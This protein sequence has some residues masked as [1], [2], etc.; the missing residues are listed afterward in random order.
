M[1]QRNFQSSQKQRGTTL[2]E[3][4][5][6]VAVTLALVTLA[7]GIYL[8]TH[9]SQNAR[10]RKLEVD[11]MGS[12][13]MQLLG[14][15]IK[16][17][18]YYP[19]VMPANGAN[20]AET[21]PPVNKTTQ[22]NQIQAWI[23]PFP[24]YLSPL[25]GCDSAEFNPN[26]G[27]CVV[28][29]GANASKFDSI[30][31]NRFTFESAP[32]GTTTGGRRDCTG[33][34]VGNDPSNTGRLNASNANGGLSPIAP[35]FVSNRYALRPTNVWVD[36]QNIA[37]QSLVCSGNGSTSQAY[38]P[39]LSG[40]EE[41]RFRYGVFETV[42]NKVPTR[43]LK[44]LE[45]NAL[46]SLQVDGQDLK[47][48]DRVVAVEVCLLVNSLGGAPKLQDKANQATTYQNC[49]GETVNSDGRNLRK[50]YLQRFALRNRLNS[51]Y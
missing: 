45:I 23:A 9:D 30:V 50:R 3:L 27:L 21:Y 8:F 26:T 34:D 7:G 43:F 47:A 36:R 51:D 6:A 29:A 13:A 5:V 11:E 40:I 2:V 42:D 49:S 20:F 48:W 10:K 22:A 28:N 4:L 12:F 37:T 24:L 33:S 35:L 38:H 41:M 44:A 19:T 14:R 16:N 17:A 18:G 46:P 31:L 25:F 39:L 32:M 15:D 1:D